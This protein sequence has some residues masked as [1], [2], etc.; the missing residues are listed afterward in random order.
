MIDEAVGHLVGLDRYNSCPG[1]GF[2]GSGYAYNPGVV[3]NP[4]PASGAATATAGRSVTFSVSGFTPTE[5]V[6]TSVTAPDASMV[7]IGS[8]Q[9]SADGTVTISL[10]FPAAGNWQITAHGQRSSKD[11]VTR[12]TV[13]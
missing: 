1:A 6:A 9:A 10:T 11:V 2:F 12:Y 5:T 3:S 4:A 8:A 13:S 7:Q